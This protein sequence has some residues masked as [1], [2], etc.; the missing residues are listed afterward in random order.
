MN[1]LIY[2]TDPLCSWCYG[3]AK[4]I[5]KI[6]QH[7]EKEAPL[8]L[9]MGGLR[10]FN[11][12]TMPELKDFLREHWDHVNQRSGQP[13]NYK[14]LNSPKFVYDTEPPAR[15]VIAMRLIQPDLELAFFK[16]VQKAFYLGNKD[17]NQI[18]A[19]LPIVEKLGINTSLFE[20]TFLAESTKVLTTN[21]FQRAKALGVRGFPT[22]L[23][24]QDATY[25]LICNGYA[26]AEQIIPFITSEM[27]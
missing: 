11:T 8:K 14:I 2:V 3:F 15:A 17:T 5:T 22:L 13:F 24:Q 10:P 4:E 21:D 9:I 25:S 19:Y 7:F 20:K 6:T 16:A 18:A 1:T 23:L 26:S 12:Q 27:I